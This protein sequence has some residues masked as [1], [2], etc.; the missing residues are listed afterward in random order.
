MSENKAN[1][2]NFTNAMGDAASESLN[3]LKEKGELSILMS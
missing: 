1:Q 3:I 2:E